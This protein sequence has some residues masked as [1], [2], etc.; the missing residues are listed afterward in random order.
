V[1]LVLAAAITELPQLKTASDG[2]LVLRRRVIALF[3][4]RTF[5]RDD[6]PHVCSLQFSV[7]S[8]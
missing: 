7:R 4:L 2:L 1:R 5:Q 6:F 3:A 8:S